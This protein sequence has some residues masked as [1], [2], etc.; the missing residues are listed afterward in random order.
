MMD[1]GSPAR[2]DAGLLAGIAALP[3]FF[4]QHRHVER[5]VETFDFAAAG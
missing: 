1:S 3:R 4:F 2:G 5:V